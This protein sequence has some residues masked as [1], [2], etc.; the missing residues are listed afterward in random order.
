MVGNI[1]LAISGVRLLLL[2]AEV[3]GLKRTT[4]NREMRVMGDIGCQSLESGYWCELYVCARSDDVSTSPAN[5]EAVVDGVLVVV[6]EEVD[7]SVAVAEWDGVVY[8]PRVVDVLVHLRHLAPLLRVHGQH[9]VEELEEARG[10]VLPHTRRLWR[11]SA[12]PLH[13]LVVV[14]V[15]E[16]RLFPREASREHA[17]EEDAERPH[18]AGRVHVEACVVGGVADLGRG[19]GDAPA[20]PGDV[21]TSA[22]GHAEVDDLDGGPLLVG[23]DNV[24]GFD[25]AVDQVLAVHVLESARNLVDVGPCLALAEADFGLDGVEEIAAASKVLHHHVRGLGLVGSVVGSDDVRVLGEVLSVL[26]LL[27][28]AGSGS[29]FFADCLDGNLAASGLVFRNPGGAVGALSGGLDESVALV[30]AGLVACHC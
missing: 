7:L 25:V 14:G 29:G 5:C 9:L 16:R 23:E 18:V 17:E 19:V 12:L 8:E 27:L 11:D 2:P 15:A 4:E 24:L 3:D 22:E 28:E 30:Q 21:D 13:E 26:E 6:V 20:D 1:R 10:E